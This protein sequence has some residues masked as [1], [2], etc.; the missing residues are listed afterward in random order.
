MLHCHVW[1]LEVNCLWVQ[2][3]RGHPRME[4]IAALMSLEWWELDGDN[5]GSILWLIISGVGHGQEDR[6]IGGWTFQ[7]HDS[8]H[9]SRYMEQLRMRM[10]IARITHL[11]KNQ[12]L[13]SSELVNCGGAQ[14]LLPKRFCHVLICVVIVFAVIIQNCEIQHVDPY[15]II[16]PCSGKRLLSRGHII[17]MGIAIVISSP[18]MGY[19]APITMVSYLFTNSSLE[20][21]ELHAQV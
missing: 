7:V 19:G 11:V 21:V 14:S 8:Y 15:L 6:K 9:L 12:Q 17:S 10:N 18:K 13:R 3:F 16:P 4:Y 2:A 1:L 5:G 20:L